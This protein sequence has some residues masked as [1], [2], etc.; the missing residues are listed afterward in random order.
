M[1]KKQRIADLESEIAALTARVND[2]LL[3]VEELESRPF[4]TFVQPPLDPTEQW[5]LPAPWTC[6]PVYFA[7]T[8]DHTHSTA[9]WRDPYTE[10]VMRLHGV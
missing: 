4:M 2:L 1:T 9:G 7:H 10:Y 8:D 3:R 5:K 6:A